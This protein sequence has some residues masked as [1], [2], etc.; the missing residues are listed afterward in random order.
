[1]LSVSM[2]SQNTQTLAIMTPLLQIALPL[3]V[4]SVSVAILY[5]R[6]PYIREIKN[7]HFT[8]G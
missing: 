7:G 5:S 1:M 2:E 4:N 6:I 3:Q 8:D